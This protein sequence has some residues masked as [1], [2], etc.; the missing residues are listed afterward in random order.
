MEGDQNHSLKLGGSSVEGDDQIY[1]SGLSTLLVATIQETKDRLSQIEFLFCSQLFPS[2]QTKSK[3]LQKIYSEARK[4]AED[5]WKENENDLLFQIEKLKRENQRILEENKSLKLEKENPS[6]ELAERMDLLR[7]KLLGEQLKAEELAQQLKQKSREIDE[8]IELQ[9][10]L[11]EMVRSKTSLIMSKEQKLKEYEDQSNVLRTKLTSMEV[12][13]DELQKKLNAKT[14]EVS[15]VKKLEENLFKKLELQASEIMNIEQ[16]NSDQQKEKQM[17]VVK[18]EK[19]QENVNR[20]EKELLSKTEEI[21][22]GRK[23]QTKLLQQI[24]SAGSEISKNTE[25]LEELQKENKQL[26]AKLNG[27]QE[28][29][30]ELKS[31]PRVKN[32]E[33]EGN[34]LYESLR[35]QI[36]LKSFELQ[37]EKKARRGV[38]DAY[39]RL[40][41]QYNFLCKKFGLTSDNMLLKDRRENETDSMAYNQD[42]ASSPVDPDAE[43]EEPSIAI[44]DTSQL[45]KEISVHHNI[46]DK[47]VVRLNQ[48]L[49]SR[50][51][52]KTPSFSS[53][54]K[55][56]PNVKS[57]PIASKRPASNWRG[58][59]T[60]YQERA[61]P[62]PHDDF[63]DTPLENIRENLNNPVKDRVKDLPLPEV[64]VKN[65][66]MDVSDDE[67]QDL[68]VVNPQQHQKQMPI[69]VTG[70]R[71]G[72]IK[73]VEPVRKKADRQNLKGV[74]CKQCKKFY[75]AVLPNDGNEE[76]NGDKPCL[77]C[78]HHDGVSRHRYRYVPPM[79]P[80]GF[81]NIGFE[82]EM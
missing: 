80:E 72:G 24:D 68:N 2:F 64:V 71:G 32:K 11:L 56:S 67:T 58:T 19:L 62:D 59:R 51:P 25:Q 33:M 10:K 4:S 20:L 14:D 82:S 70:N 5:A 36:E 49:N 81:W 38:V 47:K 76:T 66:D 45:K 27:S 57:A 42:L 8:G 1:I 74:E 31:N 61:G 3:S 53:G 17:L 7:S 41:S 50:S 79:T 28:K 13:F 60:H 39:K 34:E 46:E 43:T 15:T 35:E 21:E 44:S 73:F 77:R 37:A 78:E 75:D 54:S 55:R 9:Q 52:P 29:V 23:L 30:N 18:L 48:A 22:E 26:L 65:I 12:K 16:M 6:R 40:K 63:L 69:S